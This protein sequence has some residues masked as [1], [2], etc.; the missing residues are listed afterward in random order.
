MTARQPLLGYGIADASG[1]LATCRFNLRSGVTVAEGQAAG[2]SLRAIL[3]GFVGGSF[4]RQSIV[5]PFTADDITPAQPGSRIENR[6]ALIFE[7]AA[8]GQL[9]TVSI[10][11]IVAAAIQAEGPRAGLELDITNAAVIALVE[12]IISGLWSNP[13]GYDAVE[14]GA[15]IVETVD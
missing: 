9:L 3:S 12:E 14:L 11:A 2:D 6:A 8:T 7:T 10:P 13:F 5:Y 15:T 1:S 4:V